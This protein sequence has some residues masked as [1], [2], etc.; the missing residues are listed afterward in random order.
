MS[1][2]AL[3]LL[4][5][6]DVRSDS[7]MD[8]ANAWLLTL[9]VAAGATARDRVELV[10]GIVVV[11]ASFAVFSVRKAGNKDRNPSRGSEN[12]SARLSFWPT[13]P[14]FPTTSSFD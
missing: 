2:T 14:P 12:D 4:P 5:Q 13:N 11:L 3:H 8:W 6:H 9:L 10:V 7:R 1:A